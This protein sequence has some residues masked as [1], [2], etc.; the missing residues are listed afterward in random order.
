MEKTVLFNIILSVC[1]IVLSQICSFWIL[2]RAFDCS[3]VTFREILQNPDLRSYSGSRHA[4][5]WR[6]RMLQSYLSEKADSPDV[7]RGWL[8]LYRFASLPSVLASLLLILGLSL[9]AGA[10]RYILLGN[11]VSFLAAAALGAAAKVYQ[12]S[13]PLTP[14]QQ[15]KLHTKRR[16]DKAADPHRTRNFVVLAA[17]NVLFVGIFV[18]MLL[19]IGSVIS[20]RIVPQTQTPSASQAE[21]A[22]A[23]DYQTVSAALQQAGFETAN[24]PTTYWQI[25]EE[26]L[27]YVA[28]GLKGETKFEYY[29]YTNGESTDLVYSQIVYDIAP[30]IIDEHEEDAYE[31]A[32]SGGGEMFA[33]TQADVYTVVLYRGDTVVYAYAPQDSTEIQDLLVQLGYLQT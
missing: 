27:Q 15:E 7:L 25:D 14:L 11:I 29:A 24:V 13:H 28:A 6:Y 17:V 31:T 23:V 32:L 8:R 4:G 30:E 2:F 1:V 18:F 10:A 20:Q 26:K 9:G 33:I 3:G 21:Q 5:R 12:N 16:R 22:P 19:G